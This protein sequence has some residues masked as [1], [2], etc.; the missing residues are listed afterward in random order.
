MSENQSIEFKEIWKDEYLKWICGFANANGES[1]LTKHP[2]KPYNPDIANA[3]FR[4]GYIE[5]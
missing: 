2:S 5:S 1:L 3:F 4:S